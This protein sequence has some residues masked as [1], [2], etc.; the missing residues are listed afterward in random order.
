LKTE[1]RKLR[2]EIGGDEEMRID[3]KMKR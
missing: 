1:N 3:E 2:V